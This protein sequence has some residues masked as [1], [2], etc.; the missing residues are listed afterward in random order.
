MYGVDN[1]PTFQRTDPVFPKQEK[2]CEPWD[3]KQGSGAFEN[4]AE[5][6]LG[7][8]RFGTEAYQIRDG[9]RGAKGK[10]FD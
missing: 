5:S 8:V 10:D 1:I 4:H 7:V 2:P 3:C 9:K 6:G